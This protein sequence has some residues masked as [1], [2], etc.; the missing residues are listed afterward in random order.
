MTW[1][2]EDGE[3]NVWIFTGFFQG[4]PPLENRRMSPKKGPFPEKNMSSSNRW[5]FR[6]Y[7]EAFS[8]ERSPPPFFCPVGFL[9]VKRLGKRP[10][11]WEDAFDQGLT[12]P[13]GVAWILLCF[14]FRSEVQLMVNCWFG[15]RWLGFLG[16]PYER[17]CYL[18]APLESQTTGPQTNNWPLAE[19]WWLEDWWGLQGDQSLQSFRNS[20]S[21]HA[22]DN[23]ER[24]DEFKTC[25][26]F[27]N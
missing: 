2:P 25:N 23:R 27:F 22:G 11:M 20:S 13:P 1:N 12:L 14:L 19:K 24:A 18:R 26:A 6:E 8:S 21:N 10:M 4:Y 15:A 7:S 5:I 16:S 3:R 17:D 9:E